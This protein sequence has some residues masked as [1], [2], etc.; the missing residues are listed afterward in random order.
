[1]VGFDDSA[2]SEDEIE[3][4]FSD[5]NTFRQLFLRHSY[6]AAPGVPHPVQTVNAG[7][8]P[9]ATSVE[10]NI[11]ALKLQL[12]CWYGIVQKNIFFLIRGTN[13]IF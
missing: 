2:S 3:F 6:L 5:T 4:C 11:A 7:P 10:G 13:R 12:I 1:V 8:Q 9:Y